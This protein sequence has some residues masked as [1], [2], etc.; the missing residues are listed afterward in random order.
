MG[1]SFGSNS[2]DSSGLICFVIKIF[3]SYSRDIGWVCV[4]EKKGQ[5]SGSLL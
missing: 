2:Y 5:Q 4:V 1:L 3:R